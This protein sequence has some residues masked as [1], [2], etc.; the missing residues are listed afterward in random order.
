VHA[1][2]VIERLL[3]F[4]SSRRVFGNPIIEVIIGGSHVAIA[5]IADINSKIISSVMMQMTLRITTS[6]VYD[7]TSQFFMSHGSGNKCKAR[8]GDAASSP[9]GRRQRHCIANPHYA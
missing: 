7:Q 6:A 5:G 8:Q 2:A 3:R 1:L 9:A 4:D